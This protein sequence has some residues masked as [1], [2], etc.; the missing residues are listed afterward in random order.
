MFS[1][2]ENG[3]DEDDDATIVHGRTEFRWFR[4]IVVYIF[5]TLVEF[6]KAVRKYAIHQERN[7]KSCLSDKARLNKLSV[8][9]IEGYPFKLYAS[10]DITRASF[11]VKKVNNEHTCQ[12]NMDSYHQFKDSWCADQ[13]LDLFKSRQHIPFAK[14]VDIVRKKNFELPLV[15]NLFTR[16]S[17]LHIEGYVGR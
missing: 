8:R 16:L 4:W 17:M 2:Y 7:V 6:E 3:D 15:G 9:C 12:R 11:V 5:G 13:L 14:L 10:W 1:D